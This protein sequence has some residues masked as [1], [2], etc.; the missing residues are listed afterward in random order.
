MKNLLYLLLSFSLVNAQIANTSV[1]EVKS[2]TDQKLVFDVIAHSVIYLSKNGN[3][4]LSLARKGS[5]VE[6]LAFDH[7]AYKI[8]LD[9]SSGSTVGWVA[10]HTLSCNDPEFIENFKKV[11]DRQVAVSALIE[12]KEVAIGMTAEEVTQA[13]G[14]PTKTTAKRTATGTSAIYEY[15]EYF[16]Q[17]HYN[18]FRD[19][20][21][22][23]FHKQFSHSTQ[24]IEEQ[25]I[26]EFADNAV[27]SI[28]ETE[29]RERRR[30]S[31]STPIYPHYRWF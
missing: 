2:L 1:V 27:S 20:H 13:L 4:K 5:K 30:N 6:L 21:T 22:G 14:R 28:E 31:V 24:E 17:K 7:R 12:N 26:I 9:S 15:T 16:T 19:P 25:V 23:Q 8:K 3:N 10:P 29:S 11:Y 18:Q